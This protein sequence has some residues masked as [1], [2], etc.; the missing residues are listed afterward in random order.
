MKRIFYT[1]FYLMM[2]ACGMMDVQSSVLTCDGRIDLV[3][4]FPERIYIIEFKCDQ[5]AEIALQ[6][7]QEKQYAKPYRHSGKTITL[8]GINFNQDTRNID[9]WKIQSE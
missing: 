2:S 5:S 6:Q 3:V 4:R 8:I 1:I 9:E 7:I